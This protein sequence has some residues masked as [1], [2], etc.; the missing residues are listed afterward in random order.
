MYDSVKN[1]NLGSG[2]KSDQGV[3]LQRADKQ[4]GGVTYTSMYDDGQPSEL[5]RTDNLAGAIGTVRWVGKKEAFNTAGSAAYG[6][7]P[8]N[9]GDISSYQGEY[10]EIQV[11]AGLF[12]GTT[13]GMANNNTE[14]PYQKGHVLPKQAGGTGAGN[15]LFWQNAGQNNGG[16]WKGFEGNAT[17]YLQN[18]GGKYLY[19]QVTTA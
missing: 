16:T 17:N 19:Y 12:G 9:Q 5:W 4:F 13:Q 2:A 6:A 11:G 14:V 1:N 8:G 10:G 3:V 7:P 18:T 15:N